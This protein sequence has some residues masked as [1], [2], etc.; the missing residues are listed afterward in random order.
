MRSFI[1]YLLLENDKYY[2]TSYIEPT[3]SIENIIYSVTCLSPEWLFINRPIKILKI[4]EKSDTISMFEYIIDYMRRQGIDNVRGDTMS[5]LNFSLQLRTHIQRKIADYIETD[6]R[7]NE[8]V[9]PIYSHVQ[10][11]YNDVDEEKG[12]LTRIFDC[13]SSKHKSKNTPL[14]TT[15]KTDSDSDSDSELRT[16]L[17]ENNESQEF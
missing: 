12:Y 16:H 2:I 1:Y 7:L 11:K 4:I 17:L 5:N 9:I 14:K 13:F 15:I 10:V 6:H 3:K 8:N